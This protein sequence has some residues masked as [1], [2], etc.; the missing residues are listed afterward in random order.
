MVTHDVTFLCRNLGFLHSEGRKFLEI[1][2]SNGVK[3]QNL[4]TSLN[5]LG[6]GI[7]PS[8][9]AI[10]DAKRRMNSSNFHVGTADRL[11]FVNEFFDLVFFGF[12]LYLIDRE[13]LE[14]VF[15]ESIRVLKKD[16]Y[17]AILDFDYGVKYSQDYIHKKGIKSYKDNYLKYLEKYSVNLVAKE[18]Y[19]ESGEIKYEANPNSRV[20]ISLYSLE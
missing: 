19:S 1:G 12:C 10:E 5:W 18:S 16:G 17:I 4:M 2:C 13:D 14:K 6:Y 15:N 20:A 9:A 7:D 3:T 8:P 11:L